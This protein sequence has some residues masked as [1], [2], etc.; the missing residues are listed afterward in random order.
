MPTTLA[1]DPVCVRRERKRNEGGRGCVAELLL[2][3]NSRSVPLLLISRECF[4]SPSPKYRL[5]KMSEELRWPN[6]HFWQVRYRRPPLLFFFRGS[7]LLPLHLV[8]RHAD[9]E[10]ERV[11]A[12]SRTVTVGAFKIGALDHNW[13]TLEHTASTCKC[14]P[15]AVGAFEIYKKG[16]R[17][18]YRF[19]QKKGTDPFFFPN[20]KGHRFSLFC[21]LQICNATI[22]TK[23]IFFVL[24]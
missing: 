5:R 12:N 21:R 17:S 1:L 18:P 8:L 10:I 2:L 6:Y 3:A 20:T 11:R 13:N 9:G 15:I 19:L 4:T 23:R 14:R 24:L 7:A 16:H 22:W